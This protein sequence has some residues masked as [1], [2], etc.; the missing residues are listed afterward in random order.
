MQNMT[1]SFSSGEKGAQGVSIYLKNDDFKNICILETLYPGRIL[2][3]SADK[4]DRTWYFMNVYLPNE[5][6]QQLEFIAYIDKLIQKYDLTKKLF[7]IAGDF[8]MVEK[9]EIDKSAWSTNKP[10]SKS[11]LKWTSL[12]KCF[13]LSDTYQI[14]KPKKREYTWGHLTNVT[15]SRLDRIYCNKFMI[16]TIKSA[17]INELVHSD[18]KASITLF[19][20]HSLNAML[21]LLRE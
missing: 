10:N 6:K 7:V 9:P 15:K 1:G 14:K 20:S 8:N 17:Y 2:L 12:V 18:H 13:Q 16:N 5:V 4:E 21:N 3:L 19:Q 11:A